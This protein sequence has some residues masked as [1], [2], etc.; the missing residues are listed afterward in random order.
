MVGQSAGIAA[1]AAYEVD[2]ILQV[3]SLG[4]LAAVDTGSI[5]Y[6]INNWGEIAGTSTGTARKAFYWN[7]TGGM[8]S[9]SF[10]VSCGS[11]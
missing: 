9:G 10:R 2:G 1:T 8:I 7:S 11:P 4:V 3:Q 6:A 5:A